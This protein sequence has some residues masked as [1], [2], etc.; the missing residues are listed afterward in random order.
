MPPIRLALVGAGIFARDAHLPSILNLPQ[1]FTISAIYS[2]TAASAERLAAAVRAGLAADQQPAAIAIHTDLAALLQDNTIDAVDGVLPIPVMA[3]MVE[4]VL[5]SGKHLIS[6]KPLAADLPTC[7]RLIDLHTRPEQVWMVA[8]NWRYETAYVQAAALVRE[9][10]IGRPLTCHLALFLP[11]VEGSKYFGTTWRR[12]A[13][14]FGGTLIDGGVHHAALL[15]MVVGEVAEV[16][17]YS[18]HTSPHFAVNDTLSATLRFANGAIGT[19]LVTYGWGAPWGGDLHVVGDK[20]ALR[21]QRGL[22]ELTRDGKTETIPTAR[23]D[24]VQNEFAAFAA[25]IRGEIT[26]VNTAQEGLCDVTVVAA[27][28]QAAETGRS[29]AVTELA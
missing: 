10:A 4:A 21:V 16:S 11:M 6:E 13:D 18:S 28:I 23:F 29:V 20:G 2:R 19:Y 5:R 27:M 24:G 12:S 7:R 26:H 22:I 17:A 1:D 3:P 8:E 14:F 15:R 25:A 9:G